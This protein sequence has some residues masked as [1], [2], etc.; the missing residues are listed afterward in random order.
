MGGSQELWRLPKAA[1]LLGSFVFSRQRQNS[2]CQQGK[3]SG[4][5]IQ[6]PLLPTVPSSRFFVLSPLSPLAK[7]S[8]YCLRHGN[9]GLRPQSHIVVIY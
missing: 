1:L 5:E 6:C 3:P 8:D 7:F 4:K 9:G 2:F